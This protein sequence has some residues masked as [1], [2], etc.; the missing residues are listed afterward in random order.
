LGLLDNTDTANLGCHMAPYS[1]HKVCWPQMYL[2][3]ANRWWCCPNDVYASIERRRQVAVL[4]YWHQ[5]NRAERAGRTDGPK[6]EASQPRWI[7]L[8]VN[9]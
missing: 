6:A 2:H 9:L 3:S 7:P 8:Q 5:A 1:R 4:F